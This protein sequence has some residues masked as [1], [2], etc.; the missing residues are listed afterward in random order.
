ME[1]TTQVIV[2]FQFQS[3]FLIRIDIVNI[4]FYGFISNSN[5]ISKVLF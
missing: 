1:N 2:L 5:Y 4:F 3:I